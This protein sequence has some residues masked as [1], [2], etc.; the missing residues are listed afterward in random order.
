MDSKFSTSVFS[1]QN[2][3]QDVREYFARP[4]S[5][6][7][8]A[9]PLGTRT[10]FF[11]T[12]P[13]FSAWL[14]Y[15][16]T[17]QQRLLG[18]Y[19]IRATLVF[20]LQVAA[21]P[22]HQ[23]LVCLSFQYGADPSAI[24][25]VY[26]RS[27]QS[28]TAT[29][30]PHVVLDL[31]SD[32][33]VQ[34]KVPYLAPAEFSRVQ[35]N[36]S[37]FVYGC[38]A[39]N[40][41]AVTP[42]VAGLTA[43]T[44]QLY[45]HM[46]D[47][48]LFGAAPQSTV[49]VQ[50][51]S[52]RKVSPV[53]KEFE[54]DAYPYSSALSAG[55]RVAHFVAKGVPSLAAV[56]GATA[57]ALGKAADLVRYFGYGKPVVAD[58]V[59]R[60]NV[61]D[62]VGE[63]NTDVPTACLTLAPTV[64]N[65]TAISTHVGYSDVD[66]MATAYVRS[67]WSQLCYFSYDTSVAAG[68]RIYG[69]P[70]SPL[71]MWFVAPATPAYNRYPQPF[72]TAATNAIQPTSLMFLASSCKYWRGSIKFRFTFAKTKMH[73]GRVMVAF[74]PDTFTPSLTSAL[75]NPQLVNF[76][77]YGALG[78]DP[79]PHSAVFDLKDGNVFEFTVPYVSPAPYVTFPTTTGTLAF[80]V[81]NPLLAPSMV[82]NSISVLVEVCGGNDFEVADPAGIFL[83]VHN[84]G[85]IL[86]S[87]RVVSMAPENINEYTTGEALMSVKQLISI[88][89]S[90]Y[91]PGSANLLELIVPPWYYQ[92]TPSVL[93]PSTISALPWSFSYGGNWASCYAFIKGGTDLHLNG[94]DALLFKITQVPQSSGLYPNTNTPDNRSVA[95]CPQYKGFT[96]S[97][98][99]RLPGYFPT[100][101][102]LSWIAN[103]ITGSGVSWSPALT[104]T[105]ASVSM[106]T[107]LQAL[108]AAQQVGAGIAYIARNAA[109]D[110]QMAM[111]MGPPPV[112][113]PAGP[114]VAGHFDPDNDLK[115]V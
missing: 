80:F 81:V 91:Y 105:S 76:A 18:A 25:A 65:S 101:R 20:T 4:V 115:L 15:W 85:T 21:T 24:P 70:I 28:C 99:V 34:L 75:N 93:V 40:N 90:K 39:L 17:G 87:G 96:N 30:L 71:C 68:S 92:P 22:F 104:F 56:G 23:G 46:E 8:G 110:A 79:F 41:L 2:T 7:N 89:H 84:G 77:S 16:A 50:V 114:S 102:A 48:E 95:N 44:Y 53:A 78:P 88:P 11:N 36:S 113:L 98:H 54:S 19:G 35:T 97:C 1:V 37:D 27:Q 83:P 66:E 74:N 31:S 103:A 62:A 57:W 32:T 14:S 29:N 6:T 52:G 43:P 106:W 10:R 47:V 9:I 109:D 58:P 59:M 26:F 51:N 42:A 108:Y 100:V 13:V 67:R 94:D 63:W 69:C 3:L 5:I 12:Q 112:W 60:V 86:Q 111:Y 55:S 72:A 49:N 45:I 107:G 38:L 64:T 82:A 33:M 73:A 61:I